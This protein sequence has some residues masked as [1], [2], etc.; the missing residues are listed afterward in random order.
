MTIITRS[1]ESWD[2]ISFRI[3]GDERHMHEL[4]AANPQYCGV[5]FFPYGTELRG[6]DIVA[7]SGPNLPPW[8]R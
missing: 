5:S 2:M 8:K 1:G 7:P 6:P 3:Y 4:M